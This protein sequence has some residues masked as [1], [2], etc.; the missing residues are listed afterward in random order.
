MTSNQIKKKSIFCHYSKIVIKKMEKEAIKEK[1]DAFVTYSWDS[2]KHN[3]QVI[4]FTN[5]LR[6]K[7]FEAEIDKLLIQKETAIDFLKMMHKGMT[8]YN[9][10]IVVLSK[11]YKEKAEAFRGGVGNEYSLILRDIDTNPNKYI[12]V[13]FEEITDEILPL[14]F[15]GRHI[16]DLSK[17]DSEKMNELFAK[18]QNK[19]IYKFSNVA[20]KKPQIEEK[21]IHSFLDSREPITIEKFNIVQRDSSSQRDFSSQARLYNHI[22]FTIELSLKNNSDKPLS[23]YSIEVWF[24]P[25]STSPDIFGRI[26]GDYKVV[27]YENNSGRIFPNQVKIMKI[28][29]FKIENTTVS[30]IIEK[31]IKVV[32]YSEHGSLEK[33]FP[34]NDIE[35]K[36]ENNGKTK[37]R[38]DIFL[39]RFHR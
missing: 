30:D 1:K 29:N 4:S 12:L 31:E 2:D 17:K 38:T 8:D 11:G 3:E 14:F 37:I 18:L 7:G 19:E 6:N 39:D 28:N 33:T 24:P 15:R 10:V 34:I 21:E 5:Y 26:E 36:M 13:T 35:V 16:I 27:T 23:D 20:E 32:I 22:G 9:K 25:K